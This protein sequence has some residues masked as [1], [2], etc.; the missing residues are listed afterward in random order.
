MAINVVFKILEFNLSSRT[1]IAPE[2][3]LPIALLFN[4]PFFDFNFTSW[5]S[6]AQKDHLHHIDPA[7]M[8]GEKAPG[9][10]RG[11]TLK[12]HRSWRDR[13]SLRGF[14]SKK[15]NDHMDERPPIIKSRHSVSHITSESAIPRLQRHRAATLPV[16]V[17][18]ED[19]GNLADGESD[20]DNCKLAGERKQ[21]RVRFTVSKRASAER[22]ATINTPLVRSTSVLK[23]RQTDL[24]AAIA[25]A[26]SQAV[27]AMNGGKE[28][29]KGKDKQSIE[30]RLIHIT[31]FTTST[32]QS[33]ARLTMT[34]RTA[35]FQDRIVSPSMVCHS[36]K[37]I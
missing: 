34:S 35:Y 26:N 32:Q 30:T 4:Y 11:K 22:V 29:S 6:T 9:Y 3:P 19:H 20:D 14:T 28:G 24:S 36:S 1:P 33:R 16:N 25:E 7:N 17:Q 18:P 13:L 27:L 2:I 15:D 8:I 5:M 10:A 12:R 23:K 21:S 37:F 31:S